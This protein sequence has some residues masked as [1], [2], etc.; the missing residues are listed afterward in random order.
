MEE[1]PINGPCESAD[2]RHKEFAALPEGLRKLLEPERPRWGF[3]W[4]PLM[5]V[6]GPQ[7][8][9]EVVPYPHLYFSIKSEGPE[10]AS[11]IT[12]VI[13]LEMVLKESGLAGVKLFILNE[14][15]ACLEGVR[16]AWRPK[17]SG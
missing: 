17:E 5:V 16:E 2:A 13:L 15:I 9:F 6:S 3:D 14:V 8:P 12:D 10:I 11:S 7:L 1:R 4:G